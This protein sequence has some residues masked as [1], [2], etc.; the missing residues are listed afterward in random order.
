MSSPRHPLRA[1]RSSVFM[2]STFV[3]VVLLVASVIMGA[4]VTYFATGLIG[5]SKILCMDQQMQIIIAV[6][7][8]IFSFMGLYFMT[9]NRGGG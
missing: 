4:G 2:G 7:L 6:V 1:L 5:C 9:K 8:I 3:N